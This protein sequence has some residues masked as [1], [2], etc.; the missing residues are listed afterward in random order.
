M[1]DINW[2]V[3][4]FSERQCRTGVIDMTVGEHDRFRPRAGAESRFG[5][6]KN[7]CRPSRHPRVNQNP[8]AA[9]TTE[10][11]DIRKTDR[12][13]ADVW[14]DSSDQSARHFSR[15]VVDLTAK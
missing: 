6:G 15:E 10:K 8:F 12:K 2:N 14:R 1:M 11:I 13:P 3:P 5:R 4:H 9:G 7:V